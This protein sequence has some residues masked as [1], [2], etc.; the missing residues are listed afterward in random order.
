MLPAANRL[1]RSSDFAAAMRG[2]RRVGRSTLVVH[3]ATD[4]IKQPGSPLPGCL[5]SASAG[6]EVTMVSGS[7]EVRA[8]FIVSK[9]VGNAVI[10]NT[11]KRRLRH[12]VAA[13]LT[14]LPAGSTVVVRALPAAAGSAYRTMEQDLVTALES[15]RRPRK[16]H[17]GPR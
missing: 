7:V 9:A 2:G 15:A 1:R 16:P 13:H 6:E 4:T 17:G 10:R 8:G 14:E 5:P 11:V 3:L 12:L